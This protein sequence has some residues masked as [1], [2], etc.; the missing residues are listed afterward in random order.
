M[1]ESLQVRLTGLMNP[2]HLSNGDLT[3]DNKTLKALLLQKPGP[4]DI[5]DRHLCRG[6]QSQSRKRVLE[7]AKDS[8]VLN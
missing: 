1:N 5:T 2:G 8:E 7:Q 3:A 6:V 4:I